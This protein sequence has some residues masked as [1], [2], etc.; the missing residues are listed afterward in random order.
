MGSY[1]FEKFQCLTTNLK[2]GEEVLEEVEIVEAPSLADAQQ[3][4]KGVFSVKNATSE[5]TSRLSL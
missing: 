3:W 2:D 4:M 1:Y 5:N